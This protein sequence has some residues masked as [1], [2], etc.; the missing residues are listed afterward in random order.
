MTFEV[1]IKGLRVMVD[2]TAE[3]KTS[4]L[5]CTM[6][7]DCIVSIKNHWASSTMTAAKWWGTIEQRE[8]YERLIL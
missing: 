2:S 8:N 1:I 6:T 7:D 4:L 3:L 5:K